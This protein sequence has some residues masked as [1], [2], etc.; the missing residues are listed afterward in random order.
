MYITNISQVWE[1]LNGSGV[2]ALFRVGFTTKVL[3]GSGKG[4]V[5]LVGVSEASTTSWLCW[6]L[7]W[8]WRPLASEMRGM[9]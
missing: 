6:D 1:S 5:P 7:G 4:S 8:F 2:R 9:T 3:G